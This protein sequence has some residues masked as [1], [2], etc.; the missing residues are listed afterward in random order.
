MPTVLLGPLV[1][2]HLDGLP[3]RRWVG[4]IH[5]LLVDCSDELRR[6][7]IE[8]R[9]PWRNSDIEKQ[10]TFGRWLRDTIPD[11]V[12]TSHDPLDVTATAVATWVT[13]HL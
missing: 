10:T 2:D 8:Q 6:K 1:P 12:D 7:R 13:Q 11:R 3:A 9:P 5:Y 4:D